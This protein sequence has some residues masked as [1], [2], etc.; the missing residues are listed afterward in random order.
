MKLHLIIKADKIITSFS[1]LPFDA[2]YKFFKVHK[3]LEPQVEFHQEELNKLFE[4]HP[5][6]VDDNKIT[7]ES[8]EERK[9]YQKEVEELMSMDIE[10][11]N[12][13][14]PLI[15]NCDSLNLTVDE[16]DTLSN[17]IDFE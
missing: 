12:Y 5:Y 16:I 10:L 4:K 3:A 17:F 13:T 14:K 8:V 15:T 6:T 1:K 9:A 2:A 7:F 11:E